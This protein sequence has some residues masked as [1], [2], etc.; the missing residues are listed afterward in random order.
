MG[1]PEGATELTTL[2]ERGTWSTIEE[3]LNSPPLMLEFAVSA[4]SLVV[5]DVGLR[6]G[7]NW[8]RELE[9]DGWENR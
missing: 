8:E 2:G 7:Y 5:V 9:K 3:G 6:V 1:S 4:V